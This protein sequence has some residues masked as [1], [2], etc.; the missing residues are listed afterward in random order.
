MFDKLFHASAENYVDS[1]GPVIS[2]FFLKSKN[3]GPFTNNILNA[4]CVDTG[5][6]GIY[7]I[8]QITV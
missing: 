5:V 8:G 6:W 7:E 1:H 3:Q 2:N 4:S